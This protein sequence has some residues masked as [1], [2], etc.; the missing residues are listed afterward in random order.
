LKPI[1]CHCLDP[2]FT[3]DLI[4][5]RKDRRQTQAHPLQWVGLVARGGDPFYDH[6]M[7]REISVHLL[8]SLF[9]PAALRG[10]VAVIIDVLRASTTIVHALAA[11]A[12]QVI[13]CGEVPQAEELARRFPPGTVL[14]GGERAGTRIP[15]FDLDNSPLNYTPDVL[16]GKNL[17]FTTTNGTRALLRAEQA[18]RIVI[19]AFVNLQAVVRLLLEDGRPVHLVCAGTDGGVT[20]E[21]ALFA[22]A[23][24]HNLYKAAGG[25]APVDDECMLALEFFEARG[26]PP[27]KFRE[28]LRSSRGG[29]NL[30]ELGFDAD[31]ERA[32]QC[33][34][35]DI[36]PEACRNGHWSIEIRNPSD[37]R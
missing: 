21:D 13:P 12:K 30:V 15:G 22:G 1:T 5:D 37:K 11:G 27:E 8:P 3:R 19:G 2:A 32:G 29:R 14:L 34:L 26:K 23:V 16:Q 6:R 4:G 33:D 7:S 18:G 10:G 17:I 9:D 25:A 24:A 28:T 20:A 31:I 36:V 35:F